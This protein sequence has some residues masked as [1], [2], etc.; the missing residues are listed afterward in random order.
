MDAGRYSGRRR[1]ITREHTSDTSEADTFSRKTPEK[2][3]EKRNLGSAVHR[4]GDAPSAFVRVKPSLDQSLSDSTNGLILNYPP[5]SLPQSTLLHKNSGHHSHFASQW[6]APLL[7]PM[8]C[9]PMESSPGLVP[10]SESLGFRPIRRDS[11]GSES[12]SL[13]GSTVDSELTI[14]NVPQDRRKHSPLNVVK[15][16]SHPATTKDPT[17]PTSRLRPWTQY[18]SAAPMSRAV[19]RSSL[20]SAS[21]YDNLDKLDSLLPTPGR[22]FQSN[23]SFAP[24]N[25]P[26]PSAAGRTNRSARNSAQT[27]PPPPQIGSASMQNTSHLQNEEDRHVSCPSNQIRGSKTYDATRE[28][29]NLSEEDKGEIPQ[30]LEGVCRRRMAGGH[31]QVIPPHLVGVFDPSRFIPAG[32]HAPYEAGSDRSSERPYLASTSTSGKTLESTSFNN[33]K[34]Y[35]VKGR[36]VGLTNPSSNF[37]CGARYKKPTITKDRQTEFHTT[38]APPC[39]SGRVE[40]SSSENEVTYSFENFKAAKHQNDNIRARVFDTRVSEKGSNSVIDNDKK[41]TDTH[42]SDLPVTDLFHYTSIRPGIEPSVGR[43]ETQERQNSQMAKTKA[44]FSPTV[45]SSTS[46]VDTLK[47]A[48]PSSSKSSPKWNSSPQSVGSQKSDLTSSSKGSPKWEP[49][50]LSKE[51]DRREQT[52]S[53]KSSPR[54]PKQKSPPG[55]SPNWQYSPLTKSGQAFETAL[56]PAYSPKYEQ[57]S[58]TRSCPRVERVSSAKTSPKYDNARSPKGSPKAERNSLAKSNLKFETSQPVVKI[59]PSSQSQD[60]LKWEPTRTHM[61]MAPTVTAMASRTHSVE[62]SELNVKIGGEDDEKF[63]GGTREIPQLH[64][65][66]AIIQVTESGTK[67]KSD[68]EEELEQANCL[69][70]V[71]ANTVFFTQKEHFLPP[72]KGTSA[73]KYDPAGEK[74]SENPMKFEQKEDLTASTTCQ[75]NKEQMRT[76]IGDETDASRGMLLT[77]EKSDF[78]Q[79][80]TNDVGVFNDFY[81]DKL[82]TVMDDF[83]PQ[84]NAIQLALVDVQKENMTKHDSE[85]AKVL[86]SQTANALAVKI[87]NNSKAATEIC[88]GLDNQ[89][90]TEIKDK[91]GVNSVASDFK[92]SILRGNEITEKDDGSCRIQ[93]STPDELHGLK[94]VAESNFSE[95]PKSKSPCLQTKMFTDILENIQVVTQPCSARIESASHPTPPVDAFCMTAFVDV[96]P[97]KSSEESAPTD[98]ARIASKNTTSHSPSTNSNQIAAIDVTTVPAVADAL[99]NNLPKSVDIVFCSNYEIDVSN[100]NNECF[101]PIVSSSTAE[102]LR[103]GETRSSVEKSATNRLQN[104]GLSVSDV[105]QTFP[106]PAEK[107]IFTLDKETT[108]VSRLIESPE[109]RRSSP[110]VQ[111]VKPESDRNSLPASQDIETLEGPVQRLPVSSLASPPTDVFVTLNVH[112]LL[113]T[114]SVFQKAGNDSIDGTV[115]SLIK[116]PETA[117]EDTCIIPT[118]EPLSPPVSMIYDCKLVT[119]DSVQIPATVAEEGITTSG[120]LIAQSRGKQGEMFERKSCSDSVDQAETN[121]RGSTASFEQVARGSVNI[122]KSPAVFQTSALPITLRCSSSTSAPPC[123]TPNRTTNIG[124][125]NQLD[126][127]ATP[128]EKV[129]TLGKCNLLKWSN[130]SAGLLEGENTESTSALDALPVMA[131]LDDALAVLTSVVM[132]RKMSGADVSRQ[133]AAVTVK[134]SAK[135]SAKLDRETVS[136]LHHSNIKKVLKPHTSAKEGGPSK[137]KPGPAHKERGSSSPAFGGGHHSDPLD[138]TDIVRQEIRA[139]E[140][141]RQQLVK[142]DS[143]NRPDSPMFHDTLPLPKDSIIRR[144]RKKFCES[145][146]S[147]DGEGSPRASP[148]FT[149]RSQRRCKRSQTSDKSSSLPASEV[150]GYRTLPGRSRYSSKSLSR[151]NSD[152]FLDAQP[153]LSSNQRF[154]KS[155][156]HG[157]DVV[158]VTQDAWPKSS[159]IPQA[160][161]ATAVAGTPVR[162]GQRRSDRVPLRSDIQD[163]QQSLLLYNQQ[164]GGRRGQCWTQT[165]D[166]GIQGVG[167]RSIL[168]GNRPS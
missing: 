146:S 64:S 7:H 65:S 123:K 42:N 130:Q 107:A 113:E 148:R 8:I 56:S 46:K 39:G 9:T 118:C 71:N 69:P 134:K 149:P 21:S 58:A 30:F 110:N 52:F 38:P 109:K 162:D 121:S 115:M 93:L 126:S 163:L 91:L 40:M 26:C 133:A 124:S 125:I 49:P 105:D 10:D 84:H 139:V 122:S 62:S 25:A 141:R 117:S 68:G 135:E 23:R 87:D 150:C 4:I 11:I 101:I 81:S 16:P 60:S 22:D 131:A 129:H 140:N 99:N 151:H 5:Q 20:G 54:L 137:K 85:E 19:V 127:N 159:G 168:P 154:H 120:K 156:S 103:N 53:L 132:D 100:N 77:A 116:P 104:I 153:N 13:A 31:V 55:I 28:C 83:Q 33:P 128:T 142:E 24:A 18:D 98:G 108:F 35:D 2:G 78:P 34:I 32:S 145:S 160:M 164:H 88:T 114:P 79:K 43:T 152:F 89:N 12:S 144:N 86:A 95:D 167:K 112:P 37:A 17:N 161:D 82:V 94:I 155:H 51:E 61:E 166:A 47:H 80:V 75:D 74:L 14:A 165:I 102:D 90:S 6:N 143:F 106:S 36:E 158:G 45:H 147:S 157:L 41:N 48:S 29:L 70:S 73:D 92:K 111:T 1:F 76:L 72:S 57:T 96:Q 97:V 119:L 136:S 67:F 44:T 27:P 15:P 50:K 138:T 66:S 3:C 59:Q 63:R